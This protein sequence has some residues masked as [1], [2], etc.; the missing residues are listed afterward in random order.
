MAFT[1]TVETGTGTVTAANSYVT[2]AEADDII[3]TN[4]HASTSWNN[5]PLPNRERLLAWASRYIDD[6]TDWRG[7]KT[8]Q[9]AIDATGVRVGESPMD[10]PRTGVCDRNDIL[11][12]PNEIPRQLRVAAAEMARYLVDTD[13]SVERSQDGLKM[14]KADVVEVEFLEGYRLP[15]VP[16]NMQYLVRGLGSISGGLITFARIAV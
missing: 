1:F 5:L 3:T 15:Q 2:V 11:I 16:T 10:W 6:H 14:V 12:G 8:V 7:V 4:I 9:G 13:R